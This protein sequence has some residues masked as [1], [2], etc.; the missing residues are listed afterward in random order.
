MFLGI[1][2]YFI[3][4]VYVNGLN[5]VNCGDLKNRVYVDFFFKIIII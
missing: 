4:I 3:I 2:R 1:F 5:R